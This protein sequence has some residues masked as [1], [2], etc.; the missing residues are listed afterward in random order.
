MRKF[1][2]FILVIIFLFVSNGCY[3][4]FK[5][6]QH[7]IQQEVK[8]EIRAGLNENDLSIIVV[9]LNNEKKIEWIKKNKEF[10]YKS[11]M[12]DVV[13]TKIKNNKKYYYCRNDI[14]ER[15]LIANFARHHRRRNKILL[16]LIKLL[17]NKYF[18]QNYSINKKVSNTNFYFAEYQSLYKSRY[19]ETLSL[20][21]KFNF[22]I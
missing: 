6:L 22:N 7:N 5:Y 4:F 12:Y 18:H 21:P 20:P 1:I 14:K 3:L 2:S 17:S 13:K 8:H 11:Q 10:R 16:K 15:D 9:L 19:T